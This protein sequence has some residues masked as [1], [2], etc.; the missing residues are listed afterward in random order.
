MFFLLL[1]LI[2]PLTRSLE[3]V[4]L[5]AGSQGWGNYRHQSDIA[6][7]YQ[8]A[9]RHGIKDEQII[10]M[11]YDDIADDEE[12]PYPGQ[13]FNQPSPLRNN[14]TNV[15]DKLPKDYVGEN[16]TA[17][18]FLAVLT[19]NKTIAQGKVL[20]STSDD[21]VF[22]YFSDHGSTEL[23]CFPTGPYLYASDLM[24]AF[25]IMIEKKMFAR[26]VMYLESCE[27]GS[28]FTTLPNNVYIYATT[29]ANS[30]ESSWAYYCPPHDY[31]NGVPLNTC[32]GDEYSIHW[33]QDDDRQSSLSESLEA[34]F[35]RIRH[36]TIR[37]HVM[38]YGDKRL[39][40]DPISCFLG[41]NSD[42]DSSSNW[43]IDIQKSISSVPSYDIPFHLLYYRYLRTPLSEMHERQKRAFLLRERLQKQFT[44]DVFF[45]LLAGRAFCGEEV[46]GVPNDIP[47]GICCK[48]LFETLREHCS[49]FAQDEYT[50]Q[51]GKVFKNLCQ[52]CSFYSTVDLQEIITN[53]CLEYEED[54]P[55]TKWIGKVIV[56]HPSN[57]RQ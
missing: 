51:Y 28:M 57:K 37:S 47:C 54:R 46:F 31:I 1:L 25:N 33:L 36:E 38:H 34:Q 55:D 22:I 15:Y 11:H 3:Y 8:I 20:D 5:V 48:S 7:A 6:H 19:G 4:V 17:E 23:I 29:A 21:T 52:G 44:I 41:N 30:E 24:N 18:K 27:S 12:N 26:L 39:I 40:R 9:H 42:S 49:S 13:V 43:E 16:V 35:L 50:L 14:G 32:L 10:V 2:I 45:L 53:L 56:E